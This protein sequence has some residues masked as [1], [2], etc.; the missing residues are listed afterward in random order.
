MPS[1]WWESQG[2]VAVE[3]MINGIPVIG[4]DRGALPET[5]GD[6]G[7]VLPLPERLTPVSQIL[8]TAEEVEPWVEAIIRLWDDRAWYDEQ[9]ARARKQ[10]QAWHP[11]RLRPLYAE[12]FGEVCHQP[13]RPVL[14]GRQVDANLGRVFQA[15]VRPESQTGVETV[16]TSVLVSS[17]TIFGPSAFEAVR[18]DIGMATSSVFSGGPSDVP[19]PPDLPRAGGRA[20]GSP[21]RRAALAVVRGL[22]VG[23]SDFESRILLAS[24]LLRRGSA[25]ELIATRNCTS[26]A[27]GLNAGL[28]RARHEWVVCVHQ[29]VFLPKGWHRCLARQL[30]EAERRFGPIGVAGVYG[31]GEVIPPPRPGGAFATVR[32]RLRRRPRPDA[33]R[34]TRPA[35]PGCNARRA[36]A[37][38]APRRG[39]AI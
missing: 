25:R 23:R 29:D 10:A 24:P 36:G 20:S 38:R 1:L 2:L 37:D 27:D 39:A 30:R 15:D 34:R 18:Q 26:A 33:P 7:I 31:V 16:A 13:G 4:S 11:D 12:F 21:W 9:S 35:G 32:T 28:E 14:L 8:P 6:G 5:L 22:R 19:P 3:A 17:E